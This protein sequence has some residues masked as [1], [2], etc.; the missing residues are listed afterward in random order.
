MPD[1]TGRA[2][3]TE[4]YPGLTVC[5]DRVTGSITI[6]RSRLPLWALTGELAANGW[7]GVAENW[8]TGTMTCERFFE[9]VHHLLEA[10]QSFGRLL[11]VL[12]DVERQEQ[13]R[14]DRGDEW[15]F[16]QDHGPSARRVRRALEA[17]VDEL[18]GVPNA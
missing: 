11:C 3:T 1:L 5:N 14:R 2:K 18:L 16:W 17:C 9:F 15:P 4:D 8:D 10:R 12:A 7:A 13:E 6:D